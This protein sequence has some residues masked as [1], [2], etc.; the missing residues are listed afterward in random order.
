MTLNLPGLPRANYVIVPETKLPHQT[1][2]TAQ[3][4]PD[5]P[6]F[7]VVG[8]TASGEPID[9]YR[10]TLTAPVASL[11][12]GLVADQPAGAVP[13]QVQLFDG[14]GQVLGA[15]TVGGQGSPAL[16]AGLGALPAGST[17]YFGIN[18]GNSSGPAGSSPAVDYQLWVSLQATT[19]RAASAPGPGT[20]LSATG[21][22]PPSAGAPL[23]VATSPGVVP[24]RGDSQAAVAAPPNQGGSL[25][26]AVGAPALR[27]AKPSEG[28][29]ADGEPA[30]AVASD[31]NAA[32][33]KE[34][35]ERSLTDSTLQ[36]ADRTEPAPRA[37]RE[38]EPDALVVIPGPGGFPLVGAVALGHRRR[39]PAS[40]LE[41]GDFPT[42]VDTGDGDRP[43]A[44]ELAAQG[45]L[46]RSDN[47]AGEGDL[48][49]R[50][51]DVHLRSGGGFSFSIF[52]ALGLA[53]VFTLNAVLSQP[54]AGFDYL[55]RRLDLGGGTPPKPEGEAPKIQRGTSKRVGSRWQL[56]TLWRSPNRGRPR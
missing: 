5:L 55:T 53:T 43:D 33:N 12:F 27:S 9:L 48:T 25:G 31:F 50:S 3:P 13:F 21:T 36:P 54:I 49:A 19:A 16:H 7:G 51:G 14:S 34:W 38:P 18:A 44:V 2:A 22:V 40:A 20:T 24:S 10:L 29:F 56:L 45:L 39:D 30:P 8:T 41:L 23:P 26:V 4:L 32:V 17:V 52:S 11:D 42:T 6:Y 15:W 37:G 28:L 1:F 47:P 46:G 35:D